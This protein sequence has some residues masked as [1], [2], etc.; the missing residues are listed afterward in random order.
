MNDKKNKQTKKALKMMKEG[1]QRKQVTVYGESKRHLKWKRVYAMHEPKAYEFK[2]L[3][4]ALIV[5]STHLGC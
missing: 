5:G 3:L 2:H 4:T 1:W